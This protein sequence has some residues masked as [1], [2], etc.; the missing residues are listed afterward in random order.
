[1]VTSEERGSKPG[2][3]SGRLFQVEEG[4]VSAKALGWAGPQHRHTSCRHC[5]PGHSTTLE[6]LTPSYNPH[7]LSFYHPRP[8]IPTTP[9]YPGLEPA[10]IVPASR[11][12]EFL[13]LVY[14]ILGLRDS[15]ENSLTKVQSPGL[16]AG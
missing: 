8:G 4:M 7:P 3:V 6:S 10:K 13:L 15:W 1:M 2:A 5:K 14:Q 9:F 16:G 12:P 11:P